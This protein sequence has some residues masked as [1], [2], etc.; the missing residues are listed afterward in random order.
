MYFS[1]RWYGR[2]ESVAM[3]SCRSVKI[4]RSTLAAC[5]PGGDVWRVIPRE[6]RGPA[7]EVLTFS[8]SP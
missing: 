7:R 8:Q 5:S 4:D 3:E 2:A 6:P 1:G